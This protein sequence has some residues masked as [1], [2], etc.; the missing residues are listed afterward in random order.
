MPFLGLCLK[1]KIGK[2]LEKKVFFRAAMV[3]NGE[4]PHRWLR[5][6]WGLK[7]ISHKAIFLTDAHQSPPTA[8]EAHQIKNRWQSVAESRLV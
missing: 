6:E 4:I 8:T 2:N 7:P 5:Q 3:G 1:P